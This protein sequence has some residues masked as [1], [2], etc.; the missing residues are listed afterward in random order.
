MKRQLRPT[1]AASWRRWRAPNSKIC[2]L[3]STALVQR[4][5]VGEAKEQKAVQLREEPVV[6]RQWMPVV[7]SKCRHDTFRSTPREGIEWKLQ[8]ADNQ[9]WVWVRA[10]AWAWAWRWRWRCTV[11]VRG[12]ASHRRHGLST[13]SLACRRQK[14]EVRIHWMVP[15][16]D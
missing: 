12:S 2:R 7:P 11:G 16:E 9:V 6:Q 14:K 8:R 13:S 15:A 4:A 1:F 3:R 10:W 5:L